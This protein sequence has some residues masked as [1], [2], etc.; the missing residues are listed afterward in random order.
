M[1][2]EPNKKQIYGDIFRVI[3]YQKI[4]HCLGRQI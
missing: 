1:F 2:G 3:C 4:V